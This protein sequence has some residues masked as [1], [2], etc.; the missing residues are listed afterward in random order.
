MARYSPQR[1][2]ILSILNSTKEH[3][4]AAVVY[5]KARETMPNISLG[6]VYRNLE[7]LSSEGIIENF[8]FKDIA[9]FDGNITLHPHFC[10]NSCGKVMDLDCDEEKLLQLIEGLNGC[11]VEGK[12]LIFRGICRDCKK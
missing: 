12:T 5:E 4:S 10:C 7:K 8:N 3:P 6:T 11:E 2:L 1:E 9:H